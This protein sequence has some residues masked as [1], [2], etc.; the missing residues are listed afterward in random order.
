MSVIKQAMYR[1]YA[2]YYDLIYSGKDYKSEADRIIRLIRKYKKSDGNNLV[3]FAC[4]TGLFLQYF[5]KKF[6]CTGVDINKGVLSFAR[7]RVPGAVIMQGNMINARL[8]K[9][10]DA[11]VCLFSSIGYVK[12]YASLKKTINNFARHLK[13]GGVLIIQPWLDPKSY[14]PGSINMLTYDRP[15]LKIAR[16]NVSE[17]KG[18]ISRMD[19]HFVVAERNRKTIHFVDRHELGLFDNAK[20]LKFLRNAGIRAKFLASPSMGRGVFVGVKE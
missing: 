19:M 14:K 13:K 3:E 8:G 1:K 18:M 15:D 7:K 12:T 4:G 6:R 5:A 16:L 9:K 11:V 2:K 17:R 20:T 10:F